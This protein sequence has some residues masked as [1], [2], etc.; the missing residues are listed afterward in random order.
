MA[1]ASPSPEGAVCTFHYYEK[2][3]DNDSAVLESHVRRATVG[4]A[5]AGAVAGA[6]V[7]G[8]L[9]AG[10]Q[11][12]SV[13]SFGVLTFAPTLA[14]VVALA[15]VGAFLGGGA[16]REGAKAYAEQGHTF[17]GVIQKPQGSNLV[18]YP[19]GEVRKAVDLGTYAVGPGTNPDWW[20]GDPQ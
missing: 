12:I 14:P 15:A 6:A 19:G 5:A 7:G 2:S 4:G 20:K 10:M 17:D 8:M 3:G 16:A 9:V 11:V 13:L 1:Q 18:F